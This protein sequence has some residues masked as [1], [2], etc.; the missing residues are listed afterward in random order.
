M[1]RGYFDDFNDLRK[2]KAENAPI[3]LTR[4][5]AIEKSPEFPVELPVTSLSGKSFSL[6]EALKGKVTLVCFA[7]REYARESVDS[8]FLPFYSKFRDTEG[9][10]FFEVSVVEGWISQKLRFLFDRSERSRVAPA[11]HPSI[12]SFCGSEDD[13][14][15]CRRHLRMPS[16]LVGYAL[17]IDREGRIRWRGEGIAQEKDVEELYD[18]CN[19]LLAER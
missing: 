18:V 11:L 17:L 7:F 8:W 16:R 19:I 9:V 15:R 5:Y 13:V 3:S 1:L 14:D 4:T 12:L 2:H 10:Q 6:K